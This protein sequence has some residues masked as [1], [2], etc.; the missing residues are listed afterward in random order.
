MAI[1]TTSPLASDAA[2]ATTGTA[3]Q[4]MPEMA[5]HPASNFWRASRLWS[6]A[7]VLLMTAISYRKAAVRQ[8]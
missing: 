1:A 5:R 7:C 6:S 3:R 8:G 2:P 4:P